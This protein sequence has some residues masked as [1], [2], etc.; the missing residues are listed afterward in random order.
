MKNLS[1]MMKILTV[2]AVCS[3]LLLP[4]ISSADETR[5]LGT[6]EFGPGSHTETF[7]LGSQA[8]AFS[9]V[10]VLKSLSVSVQNG[11]RAG[12]KGNMNDGRK[13]IEDAQ[14]GW[15]K[16][17]RVS[18]AKIVMNGEVIFEQ[19]DFNQ[20]V[21]S[22]VKTMDVDDP[23]I[24]AVDLSVKVNGNKNARL[25]VTVTA[26]YE[27]PAIPMAWFLDTDVPPNGRGGPI[28]A[29]GTVDTPPPPD[30]RGVWVPL[31][32]DVR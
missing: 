12:Q 26:E 1:S 13:G 5:V 17:S 29:M 20:K 4:A 9:A 28:M 7:Y 22:L 3:I 21:S 2:V 16:N 32:G 6:V 25:T 10:P 30:P 19:K 27:Q 18:S 15:D 31:G 11:V 8:M 23:G 24:S 14:A